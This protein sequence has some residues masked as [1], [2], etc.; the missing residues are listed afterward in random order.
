MRN[1]SE[2]VKGTNIGFA[3]TDLHTNTAEIT[4]YRTSNL[5]PLIYVRTNRNRV[6]NEHKVCN[7]C[8]TCELLR[9]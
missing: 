2:I 6:E 9:Q 4:F 1:I 7:H 8:F 3:T 5:L